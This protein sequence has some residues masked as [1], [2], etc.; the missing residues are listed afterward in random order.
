MTHDT[1]RLRKIRDAAV[2]AVAHLDNAI[3]AA[4]TLDDIAWSAA[5]SDFTDAAME[6]VADS[7]AAYWA[8]LDSVSLDDILTADEI[9]GGRA[10]HTDPVL[11]WPTE[12]TR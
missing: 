3:T 5:I 4:D 6:L 7:E 10:L 1:D 9:L 8:S 12:Y 11:Y 2:D